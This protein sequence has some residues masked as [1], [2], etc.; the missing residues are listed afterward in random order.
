MIF[1]WKW[2]RLFFQVYYLW[3]YEEKTTHIYRP[4]VECKCKWNANDLHKFGAFILQPWT[5]VQVTRSG[6]HLD[7]FVRQF[8]KIPPPQDPTVG[9]WSINPDQNRAM[10]PWEICCVGCAISKP[11]DW[12]EDKRFD[13]LV[14]AASMQGG[15]NMAIC[16]NS[17]SRARQYTMS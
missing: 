7:L 14:Q 1:N 12:D 9:G 5:V 6:P 2:Q 16:A 11:F 17:C 15:Y 8:G 4:G 10:L 13:P 3:F